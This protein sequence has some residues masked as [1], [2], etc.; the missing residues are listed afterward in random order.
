MSQNDRRGFTHLPVLTH[1]CF[2]LIREVG[3]IASHILATANR[4]RASG[5]SI[6]E[7][8]PLGPQNGLA[9]SAVCDGGRPFTSVGPEGTACHGGVES[10]DGIYALLIRPTQ[11]TRIENGVVMRIESDVGPAWR[12]HE[13][14][15]ISGRVHES[16]V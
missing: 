13:A 1:E 12:W 11:L 15:P 3:G 8:R 4:C 9:S 2:H 5:C 10:A 14:F 7:G 16:I 6:I